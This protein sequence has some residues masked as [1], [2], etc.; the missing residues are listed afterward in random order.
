M[1]DSLLFIRFAAQFAIENRTLVHIKQF[2]RWHKDK[3]S[4]DSTLSRGLPWITYDAIKFLEKICNKS[5][6]VFE[7]GSGGST[8]FFATRCKEVTS[9]E[10]D[11]FW[12]QSLREKTEELNLNNITIKGVEGKPI[13]NFN[14]LNPEDPDDF[15]SKEKKSSGL[16][17]EDYVKS[18]DSYEKGSFDII[19]VDG[20]A[21]NACIKR[22]IPHI[23]AGGYL[24]VDNSDRKYYLSPFP[25]LNN[26][27]EWEKRV[28]MGPVFFQ[29]AFGKTT[30]FK[31]LVSSQ[32]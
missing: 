13:N 28:F 6:K 19:V 20:R 15:I 29:H 2:R 7:W 22:A 1:K 26:P 5:M 3:K 16:S 12:I 8:I 32:R 11:T 30:I 21:R 18:I 31:K 17:Y 23:K 9:V 25:N 4:G 24:I 14:T 10:H 27:A